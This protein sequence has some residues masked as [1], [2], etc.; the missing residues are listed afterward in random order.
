MPGEFEWLGCG[1]SIPHRTLGV[2]NAKPL[3]TK[4]VQRIM[5][6]GYSFAFSPGC[7]ILSFVE[8]QEVKTNTSPDVLSAGRHCPNPAAEVYLEQMVLVGVACCRR[9]DSAHF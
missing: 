9:P 8:M 2:R 7:S 1:F 3:L 5:L 6:S 4:P